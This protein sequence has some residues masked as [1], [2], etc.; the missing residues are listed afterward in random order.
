MIDLLI[1]LAWSV[2]FL[3]LI[4]A[5]SLVWMKKRKALLLTTQALTGYGAFI[6]LVGLLFHL[7]IGIYGVIF[8]LSGA[9]SH[10]LS[11]DYAKGR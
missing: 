9:V 6:L 2:F 4:I 1:T 5:G 10:V 11:K 7:I 8:L 3:F